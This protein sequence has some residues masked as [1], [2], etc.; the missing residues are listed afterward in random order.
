MDYRKSAVELF[1]AFEGREGRKVANL[2]NGFKGAYVI[3]RI[4]RDS[5]TDVLSGDI[6]KKMDISTARVAAALNS[7]SGK[8]YI[9]RAPADNDG[10]K[11][12]V[13]ITPSGL[14]ALSEREELVYSFVEAFLKKLTEEE[15]RA[16]LSLV[17]KLFQ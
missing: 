11:T 7:L 9:K 2:L 8:G 6:A 1:W 17:K 10:R 16:F 15:A 4:L 12:V 14:Q 3:L 13:K 5:E